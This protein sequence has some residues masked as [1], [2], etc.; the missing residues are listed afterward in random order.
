M[1]HF[2]SEFLDSLFIDGEINPKTSERFFQYYDNNQE[3]FV[4]FLYQHGYEVMK[5]TNPDGNEM[6]MV[7]PNDQYIKLT[8]PQKYG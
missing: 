3:E 6:V 5:L 4:E 2:Y 7:T 1:Q 8:H